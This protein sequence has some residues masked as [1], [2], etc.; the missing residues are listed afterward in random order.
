MSTIAWLRDPNPAELAAATAHV[1]AHGLAEL[2][3]LMVN[4]NEFHFVE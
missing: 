4:A 2:C 1:R 3:R